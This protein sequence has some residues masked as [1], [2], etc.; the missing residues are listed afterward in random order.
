M[1]DTKILSAEDRLQV[2]MFA[3]ANASGRFSEWPLLQVAVRN[4]MDS[5]AAQAQRIEELSCELVAERLSHSITS[6]ERDRQ[7][8]CNAEFIARMAQLEQERE[9]FRLMSSVADRLQQER[10]AA[11][12]RAEVADAQL[13]ETW[14]DENQTAWTRPTAWAYAQV[15]KGREADRV[16]L[17]QIR[18][19]LPAERAREIAERL[20]KY[21][22]HW[23]NESGTIVSDEAC[24]G[25]RETGA[26]L[27]AYAALVE[28]KP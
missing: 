9:K 20:T 15:C 23:R 6:G 8:E 10:D 19:A 18:E 27:R 13:N 7:Y 14:V 21:C 1:S 12:Q 25:C 24:L 3:Q 28:E 26:A 2:Q 4:F 17:R 5:H 11:L 16:L 22:I